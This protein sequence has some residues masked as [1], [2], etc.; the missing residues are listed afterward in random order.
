MRITKGLA[1]AVAIAFALSGIAIS[2]S[3]C[4]K[5][6]GD[7][8]TEEEDDDDDNDDD[9][10]KDETAAPEPVDAGVEESGDVETYPEMTKA[11]GT[12]RLLKSFQVYRAADESS[13]R[14]TGLAAGTLVDFKH[15]YRDWIMIHWPSGP[16]QLSPGWIHIRPAERHVV[17]KK[18]EKPDAGVEVVVDAGVEVKDAG[19]EVKDA[20]K[21]EDK[22]PDAGVA[23]KKPTIKPRLKFKLPKKIK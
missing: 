18:A 9:K 15:F 17:T 19:V 14:L 5:L 11:G 23:A 1:G 12:F 13:T 6:F 20:G 22:K 21:E 16:G 7:E 10:D 3:G 4:D 2:S 8:D